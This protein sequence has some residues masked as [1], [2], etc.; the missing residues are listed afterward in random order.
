M[1]VNGQAAPYIQYAYVR[2]NSILR[3][4]HFAIPEKAESSYTLTEAE[5]ELVDILSRFSQEVEK[6]AQ[7]M[8]PL[9]I[10]NYAYDLAKA[11]S[12]FYNL[13]PV[14]NAE[15]HMRNFRLALT[16]ASRQV[17]KNSLDLLGIQVP[18]VM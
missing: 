17:I 11:F 5:V 8:R 18:E 1:D 4:V 15:K 10:A 7:E 3:K 9:L 16:A 2:A 14:L 6:G 13:C 12:N